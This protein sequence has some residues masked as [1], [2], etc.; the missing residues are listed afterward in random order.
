MPNIFEF[1]ILSRVLLITVFASVLLGEISNA[2][3]ELILGDKKYSGG[4]YPIEQGILVSPEDSNYNNNLNNY[5]SNYSDKAEIDFQ[6]SNYTN[7][8]NN[9]NN[10]AEIDLKP[11]WKDT[12]NNINN[13]QDLPKNIIKASYLFEREINR[14]E[15]TIEINKLAQRNNQKVKLAKERLVYYGD[16][17]KKIFTEERIPEELIAMGFVESTYNT[18]AMSPAGAKGIWQFIPSTGKAFGLVSDEDFSDP[19]KSTRAAAKYLKYLH[20]QFDGDWLLAIAAY[21]AGETRVLQAIK[22]KNIINSQLISNQVNNQAQENSGE[23]LQENNN[24]KLI[25]FWDISEF[26]PQETQKYVPK[27]LAGVAV[28]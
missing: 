22:Q 24:N 25:S 5:N 4:S 1:K 2:E 18:S 28:L 7:I 23:N 11:S 12:S 19:V 21:N 26:L 27:V 6:A 8:N 15:V 16:L 10:L 17:F 3:V 13:N 9:L 14:Q 20:N